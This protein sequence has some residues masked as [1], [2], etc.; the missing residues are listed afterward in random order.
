MTYFLNFRSWNTGGPVV[1]PRLFEGDGTTNTLSLVPD[2]QIASIVAGKNILFATHGFN[3][4]RSAGASSLGWLD[5]YLNL[6]APSLF[7]GMLWP[8]D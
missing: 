8:G 5:R 6:N 4:S 7:I 1:D 3:V 2:I